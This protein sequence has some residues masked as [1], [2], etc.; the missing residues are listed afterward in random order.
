[1]SRQGGVV[2]ARA[3]SR[4]ARYA[5]IGSLIEMCRVVDMPQFDNW[6]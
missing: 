3:V 6:C 2:V 5:G 4:F 1:M